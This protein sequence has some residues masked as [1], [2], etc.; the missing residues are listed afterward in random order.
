MTGGHVKLASLQ[1]ILKKGQVACA[2]LKSLTIQSMTI[3]S[4]TFCWENCCCID[5]VTYLATMRS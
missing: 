2:C 5:T 3:S 1:S 4:F